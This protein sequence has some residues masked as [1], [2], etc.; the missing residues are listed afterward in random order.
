MSNTS[1]QE[2]T[3]DIVRKRDHAASRANAMT[4]AGPETVEIHLETQKER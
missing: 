1:G 3:T 4:D 2:R